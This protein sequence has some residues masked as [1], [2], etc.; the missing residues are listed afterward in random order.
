[1]VRAK[2]YFQSPDKTYFELQILICCTMTFHIWKSVVHTS[3]KLDTMTWQ[4]WPT[5]PL[6]G[7]FW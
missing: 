1:M 3:H 2:S 5:Q 7:G 6:L 4:R